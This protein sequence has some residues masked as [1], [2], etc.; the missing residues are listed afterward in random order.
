MHGS[1]GPGGPPWRSLSGGVSS[2]VCELGTLQGREFAAAERGFTAVKH[3]RWGR[4]EEE[5]FHHGEKETA[6]A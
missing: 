3:Q 1:Q 4:A 5:Q 6:V 2:W